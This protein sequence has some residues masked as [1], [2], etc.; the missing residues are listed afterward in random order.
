MFNFG[1]L[2][3]AEGKPWIQKR[4]LL[5]LFSGELK[6]RQ[7]RPGFFLLKK[8][9]VWWWYD[10]GY[11]QWFSI[12]NV[13]EWLSWWR[14]LARRFQVSE[15][16]LNFLWKYILCLNPNGNRELLVYEISLN[17]YPFWTKKK[18]CRKTLTQIVVYMIIL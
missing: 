18:I 17:Q 16:T 10:R 13:H 14:F 12:Q 9:A 7:W 8:S 4:R 3:T 5:F 6:N 2:T 1:K 11:R 15:P